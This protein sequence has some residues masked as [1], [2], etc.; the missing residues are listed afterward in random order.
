MALDGDIT[1]YKMKQQYTEFKQ[2]QYVVL[3]ICN[4]NNNNNNNNKSRPVTGL[5][6]PRG[7]VEV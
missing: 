4:N 5:K 1:A 2:M 7:W 6:W 3:S